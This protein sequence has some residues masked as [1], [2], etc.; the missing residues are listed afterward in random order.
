MHSVSVFKL[1]ITLK[2]FWYVFWLFHCH[3][4][5]SCWVFKHIWCWFGCSKLRKSLILRTLNRL[6]GFMTTEDSLM[7]L[8]W[9][10]WDLISAIFPSYRQQAIC[11]ASF[12]S[13]H[14]FP[15]R[16]IYCLCWFYSPLSLLDFVHRRMVRVWHVTDIH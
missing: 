10:F 8:K 14:F 16:P 13:W 4:V 3:R 1:K 9:L 6:V 2:L 7:Q 11:P 5:E 12:C 15:S